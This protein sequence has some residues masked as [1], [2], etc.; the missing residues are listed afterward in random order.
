[1]DRDRLVKWLL[2]IVVFS[3]LAVLLLCIFAIPYLASAAT[4]N[5]PEFEG[6]K[7]PVMVYIYLTTVPFYAGLYEAVKI[8]RGILKGADFTN[9]NVRSLVRISR[10]AFAE[11]VLYLTG[12][13][14]L[15]AFN[16]QHPTVFFLILVIVFIAV[17]LSTF[18][19]A[20]AYII[21]KA[22]LLRE[23][24]EQTI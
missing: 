6:L 24:N 20:L 1:M 9:A 16:A 10:Y 3:G 4:V 21:K 19:A 11:V 12:A 18:S 5:N 7:I 23:E 13:V 14:L 2:F 8:C 22:V 15:W 17:T